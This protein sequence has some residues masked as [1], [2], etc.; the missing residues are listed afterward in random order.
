MDHE[1]KDVIREKLACAEQECGKTPLE[2]KYEAALL[3]IVNHPDQG[4]SDGGRYSIGFVD[5]LRAAI[6]IARK[7]LA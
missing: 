4:Y 6:E 1:H 3:E 2:R 7:A 5:G